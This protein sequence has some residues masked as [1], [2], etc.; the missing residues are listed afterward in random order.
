MDEKINEGPRNPAI[1]AHPG[2]AVYKKDRGVIA[3]FTSMENARAF[4]EALNKIQTEDLVIIDMP[5]N[6]VVTESCK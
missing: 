4:I 3:A 2:Y 1:K 5:I 6:A